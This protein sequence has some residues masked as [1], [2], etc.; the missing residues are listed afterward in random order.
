M[1]P[2]EAKAR[3]GVR[4]VMTAAPSATARRPLVI[5]LLAPGVRYHLMAATF[6]VVV[7]GI[8]PISIYTG[9][10]EDW[11]FPFYEMLKIAALGAAL[12][13]AT[14]LVI[15]LLALLGGAPA[16]ALAC[17]LFCLGLYALLAHVY[18]PIQIGPLDGAEIE[19]DEPALYTAIEVGLALL[20]LVLLALLMRGR[21]VTIAAAFAALLLVGTGFVATLLWS[22]EAQPRRTLAATADAPGIDGN[23][24]HLVLDSMR[25]DVFLK[26]L[27]RTGLAPEFAGF[28]LFRNNVSN[29]VTTIPS[30]AS[31]FTGTFFRGGKWKK[32]IE[33]WYRK[34]IFATLAKRGYKVWM[35]APFPYWDTRHVDRFWYN[36]DI[37]EQEQGIVA[38]VGLHGLIQIWLAS[39]APNPLTNEALP[40][41]GALRDRVFHLLT[42]REEPISVP[43]LHPVAG[44]A[45][46]RRL[47]R[48]EALRGAHGQYV[49]AHA[50]LPHTPFVFDPDCRH[51]GQP[52][53]RPQ[54]PD[55]DPYL[56]QAQCTIRLVAAFLD[57]LRAR[58]RYD[59]AT[60]IVHADTG[61]GIGKVGKR[62]PPLGRSTLGV[63]N[64]AL[65]DG[66][67]A[68]LMIKPPH[69]KE[70]LRISEAPT[71]LVDLFP[72]VLDIL[73]LEAD[74][75]VDGRSVYALAAG[76]PR[77]V[78]FGLDP[79]RKYGHDFLEV[80]VDD[81]TDLARSPLTVVG[82]ASE[83]QTWPDGAAP[84]P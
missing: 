15:R 77:D 23:V 74:Y 50:A 51:V 59:D 3:L 38:D 21:G 12:C 8:V 17:V 82:P 11:G 35:Y 68:L 83:P 63:P 19:S 27:D 78:R 13:L 66:I 46:L 79:S 16:C 41:A 67:E 54:P 58:G 80:R 61:L 39:L 48:E 55:E 24:Y 10:G 71:Q 31:Y 76:E 65:L 9:S 44:V 73:D 49:Y 69:A 43:E 62:P 6:F 14:W 7:F 2:A 36:F 57:E 60:V 81:P 32:W 64:G 25:T 1:V 29:Y 22:H 52:K 37:L 47:R 84:K 75:P 45:M 40:L 56:Q 42:G 26:A 18:A 4:G 53:A 20:T 33:Q 30:S 72:T 28:E 5:R 34:G 70:P